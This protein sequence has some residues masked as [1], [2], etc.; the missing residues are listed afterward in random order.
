M[1]VTCAMLLYSVRASKKMASEW[2]QKEIVLRRKAA[3]SEQPSH[4]A[5]STLDEAESL[6][7]AA[8]CELLKAH[9]MEKIFH[10]RLMSW[11]AGAAPG[12]AMWTHL[13]SG[14]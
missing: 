14:E 13:L 11:L 8:H 9:C 5:E 2:K 7:N 4:L 3:L 10:G 1:V 6:Q 12:T